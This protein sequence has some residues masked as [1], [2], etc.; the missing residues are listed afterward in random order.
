MPET[1]DTLKSSLTKFF[2]A[3]RY[4]I[5]DKTMMPPPLLCI[6]IFD[7]KIFLKHR[8]G[9][10][11]SFSVLWDKKISTGNLDTSPP[12]IYKL[13]RYQKFSETQIRRVPLRSFSALWDK[14]KFDTKSWHNSL[15]HKIFRYPK[16][17]IH[18]RVPLP[19]FSAL[20]D[21]KLLTQNLDTPF[22]LFPPP[23]TSYP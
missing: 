18:W 1:S 13:F 20:W 3:V 6:K 16:L 19:N 9:L 11:R 5:F 17:V 15:K 23:P 4:K 22:L 2:G 8:R 12:L 7:T 10:L 14:K 21:K